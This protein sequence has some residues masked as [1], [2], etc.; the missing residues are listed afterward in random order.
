MPQTQFVLHCQN[1]AFGYDGNIVVHHL[2]FVVQDGDFLL[3]AGENGSGKS[4]LVKGLLRLMPPMEGAI[5]FSAEY[6]KVGYLS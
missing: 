2:N 4:T 1:A 3:I 6:K 5:S